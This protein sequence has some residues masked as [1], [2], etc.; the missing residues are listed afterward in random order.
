MPHRYVEA[1]VYGVRSM[2]AQAAGDREGHVRNYI[3]MVYKDADATL[4]RL[5][6]SFM[7]AAPQLVL[8]LY[9]LASN[10]NR[11]SPADHLSSESVGGVERRCNRAQIGWAVLETWLHSAR[12][13]RLVKGVCWR[14][15]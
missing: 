15:G 10:H 3:Y 14:L 8:Q 5:F 6:E 7:E 4:L 1:M 2:R 9:I 11:H 12:F 13:Y